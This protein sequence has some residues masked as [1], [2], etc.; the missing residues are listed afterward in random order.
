MS[1]T[2]AHALHVLGR[3]L[4]AQLFALGAL[5]KTL[6]P[7]PAM[8]LLAERGLPEAL[9]WPA[10][11]FNAGAAL[12]LILG[13]RL[14]PVGL[15]VAGYCILTSWFHWKPDDPWQMTIVVKNWAV[16]GGALILAACAA[17]PRR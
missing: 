5:Q 1:A 6:D 15:A 2:L 13:W 7:A 10:L 16:A 17:A 12:A 14:A 3:L 4:L 11:L 8:A 9:I